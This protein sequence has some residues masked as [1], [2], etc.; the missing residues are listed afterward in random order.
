MGQGEVI[1]SMMTPIYSN[2]NSI[3]QTTNGIAGSAGC[4]CPKCQPCICGGAEVPIGGNSK[5]I[6]FTAGTN[7]GGM[8]IGDSC[9]YCMSQHFLYVT[10]SPVQTSL[11]CNSSGCN[12]MDI[13]LAQLVYGQYAGA[14][15]GSCVTSG[16]YR[17]RLFISVGNLIDCECTYG[18]YCDYELTGWEF[19]TSDFAG[20]D[21]IG[22]I[23]LGDFCPA[24]L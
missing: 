1:R 22:N 24:V 12:Y 4:C 17:I 15:S 19:L 14:A 11:K 7:A 13:E 16:L 10:T 8:T 9:T 21:F 6:I 5:Q 20:A 2:G 3:I 23:T 18:D